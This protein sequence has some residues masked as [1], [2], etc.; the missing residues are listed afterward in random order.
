MHPTRN[1]PRTNGCKLFITKEKMKDLVLESL[2]SS[3]YKE[4]SKLSD[5]A[6]RELCNFFLKERYSIPTLL[7]LYGHQKVRR[8]LRVHP[9]FALRYATEKTGGRFKRAE[10]YIATD[11]K[12]AFLYSCYFLKARFIEAEPVIAK[13]PETAPA[14]YR[15]KIKQGR[16]PEAEPVFLLRA[17]DALDYA[18]SGIK[19]RWPEAEPVIAN[20]PYSA[21]YY[22]KDILK[23][24]WPEAE[25]VIATAYFSAYYYAVDILKSRFIDGEPKIMIEPYYAYLYAKDILKKR[26]PEAEPYILKDSIWWKYYR[27]SL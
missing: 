2:Q 19:G 21:Y 4:I 1:E 7:S 13:D 11:P 16:W 5:E 17:Q 8:I 20:D 12:A 25:P 3:T 23:S 27:E 26:W 14:Y 15:S 18:K 10:P 6:C 24:R 9:D 22:A